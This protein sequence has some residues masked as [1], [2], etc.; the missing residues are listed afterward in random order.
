[1]LL[2][3]GTLNKI[4]P[5]LHDQRALQLEI[6]I[7]TICPKYGINTADILH[8]FL[9]NVIYECQEFSHYEE[10]LNYTP[11]AL[12][13]T[14][15]SSRI[16]SDDA[17]KYGR[18]AGHPADQKAIGNLIYGGEFG[19]K[20]LGNNQPGDGYT[21]RGS[22]AIQLTGRNMFV[23][24]GNYMRTNFGITKTV[25]EWA[26]L[27]RTSDEYAMHSACWFFAVAKNLIPLAIDDNMKLIVKR[28]N[29]G[30]LGMPE[31]E[32]YLLLCKQYIV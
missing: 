6:I 21:F 10:S 7:N 8:E 27:L 11:E 23:L 22:G 3:L 18:S 9:A 31:R 29:G 24:F 30:Y 17:H 26:E 28:I 32:K 12:I 1:M 19:K 14:F 2:R 16:S 15:S 4:C 5:S 25:Y 20:N 13:K